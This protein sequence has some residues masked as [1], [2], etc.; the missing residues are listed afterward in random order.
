M[1][2]Q[3][4]SLTEDMQEQRVS[5]NA[6][7]AAGLFLKLPVKRMLLLALLFCSTFDFRRQAGDESSFVVLMGLATAMLAMSMLVQQKVFHKSTLWLSAPFMLFFVMSVGVAIIRGVNLYTAVTAALPLFLFI[8]MTIIT[9]EFARTLEDLNFLLNSIVF[10]AL[11]SAIWKFVFGLS[12]WGL[13]LETARYQILSGSVTI[14]FAYGMTCIFIDWRRLGLFAV[15]VSVGVVLV[16]VTR[17]FFLGYIFVVL[18]AF[19]VMPKSQIRKLLKS[20]AKF[21]LVVPLALLAMFLIA[22]SVFDRWL[23]RLTATERVGFDPTAYSRLAESTYQ[24]EQVFGSV[25]GFLFGFGQAAKTEYSGPFAD[26]L[27]ALHGGGGNGGGSGYGHNLFVGILFL[28]GFIVGT[29]VLLHMFRLLWTGWRIVKNLIQK[30]F[31]P[32]ISFAGVWGFSAFTGTLA[33][34]AFSGTW[35]DRSTSLYFG[36]SIGLIWTAKRMSKRLQN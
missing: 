34:S 22:P 1:T 33:V 27:R 4:A 7:R 11:V 35:G 13:N 23:T 32:S 5:Y 36:I 8:T 3:N 6:P 26:A 18:A 21:L 31:A 28:A 17:T 15:C 19:S 9:I 20:S 25:S 14:L 29:I 10:F 12:Y 2:P 24:L 30:N 16:S